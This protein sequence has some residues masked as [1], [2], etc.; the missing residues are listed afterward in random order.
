MNM[1]C[2]QRIFLALVLWMCAGTFGYAKDM[3]ISLPKR[4]KLTP[5]QELN[6]DGVK[7]LQKHNQNKA[8]QLFYKAYM[9][10]PDDP[11]TL[12]NLGY[13]S[14][15]EGDADRALRYYELSSQSHSDAVI[16]QASRPSLKGR[17]LAEAFESL[18]GSEL[19]ANKSNVKAISLIG[20][21]RI[22]EAEAILK[23]SLAA[24]AQNPFTLNNL[25][26]V[27]ESEGDLQSALRYYSSAAATHSSDHILVAPNPK[28][29]GK[30]ISDVAGENARA[31]NKQIA[32]GEDLQAQVARLNLRGVAALNHNDPQSA[33]SFFEEA[34]KL[35]PKNAFSLNNMG[36]I[37][38]LNGDRESAQTYYQEA[39]SASSANATVTFASRRDAE[40][41]KMGDVAATNQVDVEGAI[42]AKR[43]QRLREA[44][45]IELKRRDN[46]VVHEPETTQE[47]PLG[48][49]Q[50]SLPSPQ[51]PER[52]P[53]NQ[54]PDTPDRQPLSQPEPPPPPQ[55]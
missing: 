50:P 30:A 41:R 3:K 19:Q 51:L 16:D 4:S 48:V 13:I 31:V 5:V 55:Q 9:L 39:R 28:W 8:K 34:Y 43:E 20:K 47:P 35:D 38:E 33:R 25:G 23:S 24:S 32:Q 54:T 1:R 52:T 27:M 17:P 44:G 26:Y 40:G 10:D 37:T 45:P 11:F 7:A 12:N 6:R 49:E 36:Y 53:E 29:R 15:L 21:G 18:Q 46:S 14:E 42:E 2:R 22:T